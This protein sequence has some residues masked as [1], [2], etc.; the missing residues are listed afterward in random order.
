MGS[1]RNIFVHMMIKFMSLLITGIFHSQIHV[2]LGDVDQAIVVTGGSHLNSSEVLHSDGTSMCTLP[3]MPD[4][5]FGHSQSAFT[6]CGGGEKESKKICYTFREGRWETLNDQ[7]ELWPYEHASWMN[8]NGDILL[9]GGFHGGIPVSRTE[10]VFKDGSN[11]RSYD[12]KYLTISTC[13]IEFSDS[14]IVTGGTSDHDH[15]S[16]YNA[17]GWIRDYPKLSVGRKDHGCGFYVNDDMKMVLLVTG[18]VPV[19]EYEDTP[20]T[21]VFV[22]GASAWTEGPSLPRAL[23]GLRGVS[24]N[25]EVLMLG[26]GEYQTDVMYDVVQK[27]NPKIPSWTNVGK[28]AEGRADHAVS[29]VNLVEAYKYCGITPPNGAERVA[30]LYTMYCS[31]LILIIFVHI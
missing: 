23:S 5:K 13:T 25:N 8:E 17:T 2:V 24:V 12:A 10:L 22:E 4:I 16:M 18:G 3:P 9:M 7:L 15:V 20:S 27:F 21:E 6:A 28:L 31:L 30:S 1:K 29:K 11:A 26:G 14:F 19:F